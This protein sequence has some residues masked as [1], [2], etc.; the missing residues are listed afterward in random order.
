MNTITISG[1]VG[2]VRI[3]SFPRKDKRFCDFTSLLQS[4][5]VAS[6]GTS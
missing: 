4:Y 5:G 3:L 1:K 6:G 2:E